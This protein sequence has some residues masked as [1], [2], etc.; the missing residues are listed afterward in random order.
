M[1][2]KSK[3]FEE[4]YKNNYYDCSKRE[5]IDITKCGWDACKHE[6]FQILEKHTKPNFTYLDIMYAV[7]EIKNL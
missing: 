2:T 6:V 5:D 7:N 3:N 4:W 1:K